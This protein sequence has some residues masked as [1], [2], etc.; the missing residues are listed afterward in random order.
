MHNHFYNSHWACKIYQWSIVLVETNGWYVL[1]I[2]YI[3]DLLEQKSIFEMVSDV[4]NGER[5]KIVHRR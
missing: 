3:F 1:Y 5:L 2:L 4:W